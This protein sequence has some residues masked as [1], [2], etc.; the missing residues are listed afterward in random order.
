MSGIKKLKLAA[1][2][3]GKWWEIRLKMREILNFTECS[4]LVV[5]TYKLH[6]SL[7]FTTKP[8]TL[9]MNILYIF[10]VISIMEY[11]YKALMY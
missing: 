10:V 6:E 5:G 8:T 1:I 2:T 9:K 11:F 4:D 7:V 3:L